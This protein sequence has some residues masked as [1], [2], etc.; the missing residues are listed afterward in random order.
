MPSDP[1]RRF[2]IRLW[3]CLCYPC[4]PTSA[5][6]NPPLPRLCGQ[7]YA[8]FVSV[9][10]MHTVC[11]TTPD[12]TVSSDTLQSN[13]HSNKL[14]WAAPLSL[15]HL[16]NRVKMFQLTCLTSTPSH[17]PQSSTTREIQVVRLSSSVKLRTSIVLWVRARTPK[18]T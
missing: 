7:Y 5:S 18:D 11:R 2:L 1:G 4:F 13:H 14:D 6:D 8:P 3:L 12:A 16:H 17:E 15:H 9:A 10:S